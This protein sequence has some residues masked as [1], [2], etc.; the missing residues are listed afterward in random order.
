LTVTNSTLSTNTSSGGAGALVA[1][2]EQGLVEPVQRRVAAEFLLPARRSPSMGQIFRAIPARAAA[3]A[4]AS[5]VLA[6]R[7]AVPRLALVVERVARAARDLAALVAPAKVAAY[8][9]A[10]LRSP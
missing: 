3:E 7:A 1:L 5:A 6:A 2:G 9:P 8:F 10:A 4:Q